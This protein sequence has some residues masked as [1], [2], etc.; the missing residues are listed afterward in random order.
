MCSA[1]C[2]DFSLYMKSVYFNHKRQTKVITPM[3]YLKITELEYHTLYCTRKWTASKT[4]QSSGFFVGGYPGQGGGGDNKKNKGSGG[5]GTYNKKGGGSVNKNIQAKITRHNCRRLGHMSRNCFLPGGNLHNGSGCG[6]NKKNA[7]DT[8][9]GGDEDLHR[10]PRCNKPRNRILNSGNEVKW[11][12]ECGKPGDYFRAQHTSES[13]DGAISGGDLSGN[14]ATVN[15]TVP[16][17][18]FPKKSDNN[19]GNTDGL[20]HVGL[21]NEEDG[22]GTLA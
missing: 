3:E 17:T 7:N 21:I 14:N 20:G 22:G 4:D 10:P 9:G 12:G 15:A 8:I 1:E 18:N 19:V 13:G 5:G 11:F 16:E 2:D 6:H